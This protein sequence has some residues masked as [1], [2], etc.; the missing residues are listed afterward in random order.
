M[1]KGSDQKERATAYL[2]R[3]LSE[4]RRNKEYTL[5]TIS[6][7]MMLEICQ[8]EIYL[9]ADQLDAV[10]VDRAREREGWPTL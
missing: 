3:A 10:E 6:A 1:Y 4:I 9:E 7:I 8:A 5:E 2:E